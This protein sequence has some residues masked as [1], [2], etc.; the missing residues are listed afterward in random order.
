MDATEEDRGRRRQD[1]GLAAC[2]VC[3]LVCFGDLRRWISGWTTGCE[4]LFLL[5]LVV[6]VERRGS[7]SLLLCSW[8]LEL[9]TFLVFVNIH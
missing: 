9:F 8:G 3:V 1:T 6:P 5:L 4:P 7:R 2:V